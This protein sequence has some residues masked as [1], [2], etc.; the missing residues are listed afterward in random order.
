MA[1]AAKTKTLSPAAGT[2]AALWRT[3][4]T[5]RQLSS[6]AGGSRG[7]GVSDA[8]GGRRHQH[9]ALSVFR[10]RDDL[11]SGGSAAALDRIAR[12]AAGALHRLEKR[13]RADGDGTR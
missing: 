6:L 1:R 5:G 10:R 8:P 2:Q 7:R 3:G 4:A 12:G 9:G 13:V 11:G